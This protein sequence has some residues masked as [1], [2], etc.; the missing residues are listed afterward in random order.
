MDPT[1]FNE[2]FPDILNKQVLLTALVINIIMT[3]GKEAIPVAL[4]ESPKGKR[5]LVALPV[6]LGIL[7]AV[8]PGVMPAGPLQY[9]LQLGVVTGA[10]SVYAYKLLQKRNRTDAP[11]TNDRES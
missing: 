7:S 6:L 2:V 9:R 4:Q 1:L 5:I 8:I 11:Q 3:V 10:L